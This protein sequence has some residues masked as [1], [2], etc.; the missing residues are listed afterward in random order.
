VL[1]IDALTWLAL[2][3]LLPARIMRDHAR[4]RADARTRRR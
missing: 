1:V 2:V 4:F 3:V